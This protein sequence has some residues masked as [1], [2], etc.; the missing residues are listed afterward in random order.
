MDYYADQKDAIQAHAV[1]DADQDL[2]FR[3]AV[4]NEKYDPEHDVRDMRRLGRKQEVK[5]RFRFFSIIG[6]MVILASTWES[7]LVTT[8]FSLPNG[9]TAGTIWITFIGACGMFTSTLSMAE[10][11]SI[12]PTAGG[13]YHWVSE[14]AT[15]GLQKP[16]SYAVGWMAALGWQTA[17]PAV[18]YTAGIQIIALI[19]TVNADYLAKSW[20]SALLTIAFVLFAIIFN[21]FAINKMPLI[22]GLVVI[23]HLFGFFA[24][25]VVLWVTGPRAPGSE[26]FTTFSDEYGWGNPGLAMLVAVVGPASSMIG[27]DAAVH[28]AEELQDASYVLPRAMIA[29]AL[30]NYATAFV[31]VIS[32]VSAIGPNLHTVL[33]SPTGQPWV[34]IVR[35]ATG[36]QTAT[37]VLIVLVCFQFTFTSINQVTTSSRQLWALA[38]DKG[39]PFHAFLSKVDPQ[40]KVPRNAV[41]LTLCTTVIV[42]L[43]IIGSAIAFNI[44]LSLCNV[45]LVAS[46]IICIFHITCEAYPLK[47]RTAGS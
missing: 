13:Q 19:A 18:A 8:I 43:I 6:Y 28:L 44:I 27:A 24:F 14:F 15:P 16:L 40:T 32:L 2:A 37:I 31:M 21:M 4:D 47:G 45:S 10:M 42:S 9:G 17:M 7:A 30:I 29:S 36:S 22:E 38:R 25:V 33:L 11:A 46:Y 5:R 39:V 41:V 12:S 20:H 34:E 35:L 23:I 1:A 3:Q 26:T